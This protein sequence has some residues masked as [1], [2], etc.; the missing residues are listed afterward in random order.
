MRTWL[1]ESWSR[2]CGDT[3]VSDPIRPRRR[4]AINDTGGDW[5][6]AEAQVAKL[7]KG[8]AAGK[9]RVVTVKGAGV[10]PQKRKAEEDPKAEKKSGA[11][12]ALKKVKR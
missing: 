1:V 9:S 10:S 8:D 6:M 3:V 12:R 5:T 11:R 4:Y 7:A 2:W